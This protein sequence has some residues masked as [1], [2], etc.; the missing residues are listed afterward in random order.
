[1]TTPNPLTTVDATGVAKA[2]YDTVAFR[3][4]VTGAGKNTKKAKA[5]ARPAI[6]AVNAEIARFER[7]GVKID[8]ARRTTTCDVN[9]TQHYD[10]QTNKNVS[11]GYAATYVISFSTSD[12]DRASEIQDALSSVN[13]AEVATPQYKLQNITPLHAAALADAK[14]KLDAKFASQCAVLGLDRGSYELSSYEVRQNNR[15]SAGNQPM[16]L[17][18]MSAS[19]GGAPPPVELH[20]GEARVEVT[21]CVTYVKTAAASRKASAR[22][23]AAPTAS[24]GSSGTSRAATTATNGG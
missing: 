14:A 17:A 5:D 15:E 12:V 20:A 1:M 9:V 11:T 7:D 19:G 2:K 24:G 8:K 3:I 10:N 18:A 6:D 22:S 16:R 21:L 13:L 4:T 23:S